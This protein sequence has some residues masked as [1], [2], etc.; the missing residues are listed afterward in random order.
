MLIW[1]GCALLTA[2]AV[3]VLV[4]PLMRDAEDYG[5]I[6]ATDADLAVY[7]DQLAEIESD[8][9]RGLIG[10][11]EAQAATTETARRILRRSADGAL[12]APKISSD[13]TPQSG[14]TEP[15]SA[16]F[17][18]S[19]LIY[20]VAAFLPIASI[21]GYVSLGAPQL[22]AVPYAERLKKP[23][24]NATV[25]ELVG[26]VEERLRTNPNDGN[27]WDLIAPIYFKLRRFDEAA[28]AF[29]NAIRLQGDS[30]KRLQ[31]LAEARVMADNG[32]VGADARQAFMKILA[33]QPNQVEARFWLATA[34]EQDGDLKSAIAA[35]ESLLQLGDDKAPWR[36]VV[37]QRLA[38]AQSKAGITP[39]Q[40][41]PPASGSGTQ[42]AAAP[43]SA[44]KKTSTTSDAF[45]DGVPPQI[46]AM[47]E[48]LA[49]KLKADGNNIEGWLRLIKSYRVLG[50]D[51]DAKAA[52]VEAKK[53]FADGSVDANKIDDLVAE[54]KLKD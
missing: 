22:P 20:I 17:A 21:A 50:R 48:G 14:L 36:Q 13:K 30:I 24:G 29:S 6:D 10:L 23:S 51:A 32:M 44:E 37:K 52:S 33:K 45:P 12:A 7:R 5:P 28:M 35:Y 40:S 47:V 38:A 3:A 8:Q 27:G 54:L 25:A 4:R 46:M 19:T 34:K 18:P 53:Y 15:V 41:G 39:K 1:I 26:K 43:I 2:I 42:S 16:R 11:E 31:G 9:A 49:A